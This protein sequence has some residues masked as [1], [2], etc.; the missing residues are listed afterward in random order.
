MRVQ[1]GLVHVALLRKI[2][3]HVLERDAEAAM[4][5]RR[6][7]LTDAQPRRSRGAWN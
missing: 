5:S 7:S 2:T 1:A 6:P 4:A 3:S